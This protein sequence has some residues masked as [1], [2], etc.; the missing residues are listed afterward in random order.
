MSWLLA[1]ATAGEASASPIS[2][3]ASISAITPAADALCFRPSLVNIDGAAAQLRTV[4]AGDGFVA[5]FVIG[6]FDE[7]EAARPS[8]VAVGQN[9]HAI[10]LPE[11]LESLAQLIFIGV[12]A[13][14]PYKYVFHASPLH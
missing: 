1:V 3:I 5:L 11:S 12:E 6:H 4:Q 2:S 10:H 8:C 14:I 9:A 7:A 13:E